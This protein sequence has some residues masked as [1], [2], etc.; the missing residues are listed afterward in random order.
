MTAE[1]GLRARKKAATRAA[2]GHAAMLLVLEHGVDAV[3][4]ED[5]AAAADVSPRTFHNYFPGK[6]DAIVSPLTDLAQDAIAA[7]RAR[8]DGEPA[9]DAVQHVVH[10]VL[11]PEDDPGR[12]E[13]FALVRVIRSNP[14]LLAGQLCGLDTIEHDLA[15]VLAERTGTD[16]G[17]DLYPHLLACAA[18]TAMRVVLELWLDRDAR[19]GGLAPMIDEAFT[20]MRAGLPEPR[21]VP[22]RT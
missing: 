12:A 1:L 19:P 7:L 10:D 22:A 17:R 18:G 4:V 8:P 14:G 5:I 15:A 2:L 9:W 3:T 11:L 16:A 13:I 6:E 21:A 20:L